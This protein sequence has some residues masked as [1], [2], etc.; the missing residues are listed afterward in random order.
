MLFRCQGTLESARSCA[1]NAPALTHG[2]KRGG[3]KN[4]N[5]FCHGN[6]ELREVQKIQSVVERDKK[7]H[8]KKRPLDFA[9]AAEETNASD[10]GRA[11]DIQE[12]LAAKDRRSRFEAAGK[13]D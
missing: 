2:I 8:A 7:E 1:D 3:E 4:A 13:D 6:G 9:F 5:A 10:H 11:N 12:H